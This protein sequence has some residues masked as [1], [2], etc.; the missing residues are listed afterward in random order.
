MQLTHILATAHATNNACNVSDS[1]K[2]GG[3]CDTG[4]PQVGANSANLGNL[5]A[6]VFGVIAA[7]A[8]FMIL[9]GGFRYI[10]SQGDPQGV[11]KAKSTIVYALVGLIL[12]VSA[13]G[14]VAFVLGRL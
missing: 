6:I 8:V 2:G 10:E 9:L 7:L 4:L 13:E 5:L 12:A 11:S 3:W 1:T 14:I